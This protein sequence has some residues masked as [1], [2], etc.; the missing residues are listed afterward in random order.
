MA[1]RVRMLLEGARGYES[2]L[3][4]LR[5]SDELWG[6]WVSAWE[7]CGNSRV[8][9]D[10]TSELAVRARHLQFLF[11]DRYMHCMIKDILRRNKLAAGQGRPEVALRSEHKA[12]AAAKPKGVVAAAAAAAKAATKA[13]ALRRATPKAAGRGKPR[14][15]VT[16]TTPAVSIA[17]PVGV[18]AAV[19]PATPIPRDVAAVLSVEPAEGRAPKRTRRPSYK[20]LEA[21]EGNL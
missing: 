2:I 19:T 7:L 8:P 14:A 20:Q 3:A 10:L 15:A 1:T 17:T 13:A 11:A 16:T 9:T 4:A 5:Y 12:A 18:A 21:D 6:L